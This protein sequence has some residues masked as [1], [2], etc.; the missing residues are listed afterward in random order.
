MA[1]RIIQASPSFTVK[2]WKQQYKQIEKIK[3]NICKPHILTAKFSNLPVLRGRSL[4]SKKISEFSSPQL[5]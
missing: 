1:Q 2:Q 5:I 3:R 4:Q